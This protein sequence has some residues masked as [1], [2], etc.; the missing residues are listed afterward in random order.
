MPHN[1]GRFQIGA[2]PDADLLI[3]KHNMTIYCILYIKA[4]HRLF[5]SIFS[6]YSVIDTVQS[7]TLTSGYYSTPQCNTI[8]SCITPPY[9]TS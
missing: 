9:S 4:L 5:I 2:Y 8:L 6:S 1:V 3:R 7:S